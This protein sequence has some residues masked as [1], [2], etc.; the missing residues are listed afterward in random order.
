[1]PIPAQEEKVEFQEILGEYLSV[2]WRRKWWF[3][4]VFLCGLCIAALFVVFLPKSY[5]STTLIIVETQKIPEEFVR[6]SI[7]SSV[8]ERLSTI[9]Q[10]VLS[11]SF[12]QQVV[13]KFGLYKNSGSNMEDKV[14]GMR[15]MI[16]ITTMGT[17]Q[18]V[19]A[20]SIS[21][22]DS[23]PMIAMNVTNELSSLLIREN[24]KV[25]EELVEGTT[26]FI[27]S[28]LESLRRTLEQ[29]E[30]EISTFKQSH[31]GE[32]P[33]QIDASLRTLDRLQLSHQ[34]IKLSIRNVG[35]AET[36]PL[37]QEWLDQ[38]QKL[39]ALQ[40]K[41]SDNHPDMVSLKKEV[42]ALEERVLVQDAKG[43][44]K[45]VGKLD[46]E[47]LN[48]IGSSPGS[49]TL[50]SQ[51]ELLDLR[52][53]QK[54]VESQI[55]DFERR[56][57]N[58]PKREQQ[59]ATLLRDYENTQKNYQLLLDKKLSARISENLEK[60]QKGEQFRVVDSA[61]LP[62]KPYRPD[63]RKTLIMGIFLSFVLGV[64]CVF[65]REMM[66]ISIRKP[67]E[68][69]KLSGIPVL[70]SIVRYDLFPE[71]GQKRTGKDKKSALSVRSDT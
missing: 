31:T 26:A 8:E 68:L 46:A 55:L 14:D 52:R 69:E 19:D 66:D 11:R 13:E 61:N 45:A 49:M 43:D 54:E 62:Q 37:L 9:R 32:L 29:Q 60:R 18:R 6:S 58:A 51:S 39:A 24:L 35:P 34:E 21:F 7:T 22:I 5:K 42:K 41:Y 57:E 33:T 71:P 17:H 36:D 30:G 15:A 63:P 20:F 65:A 50:K 67:D 23:N 16:D 4:S 3:L 47:G 38:K 40:R 27:D 1:M 53:R 12:L 2:I 56:I 48:A 25:R 10:Q 70:A 28:E 44:G 64:G 59:L